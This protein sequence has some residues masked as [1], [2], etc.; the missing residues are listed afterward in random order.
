MAWPLGALALRPVL[1]LAFEQAHPFLAIE[2]GSC[3]AAV[4]SSAALRFQG[5]PAVPLSSSADPS[6]SWTALL[7]QRGHPDPALT[8][9]GSAGSAPRRGCEQS[10]KELVSFLRAPPRT[11]APPP[12][13]RAP[14]PEVPSCGVRGL[15]LEPRE[16]RNR[17]LE[18]DI[19]SACDSV[20]DQAREGRCT[21][22][23]FVVAHSRIS[24]F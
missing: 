24:V 8:G 22:C 4:G 5:S 18:G 2:Q 19:S 6:L 13:L 16:Q 11:Q 14:G 1:P 21:C 17:A 15:R 3:G 20:I 9:P 23:R 12:P 10:R 7:S